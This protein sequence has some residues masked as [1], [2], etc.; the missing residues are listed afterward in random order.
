MSSLINLF[1]PHLRNGMVLFSDMPGF[2]ASHGGTIPPH[3]LV[4]SLKPDIFIAYVSAS[5]T[6]I[7]S[8]KHYA[9]TFRKQSREYFLKCEKHFNHLVLG[10]KGKGELMCE[11]GC[12]MCSSLDLSL[13]VSFHLG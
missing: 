13:V 8:G 1:R 6:M 3:I 4:T 10:V 7:A 2:Q 12:C 11:G 9:I 5:G